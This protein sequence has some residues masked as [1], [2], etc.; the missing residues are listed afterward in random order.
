MLTWEGSWP[1]SLVRRPPWLQACSVKN[2]TKQISQWISSVLV[3]P[4]VQNI[5]KCS[6]NLNLYTM[7]KLNTSEFVSPVFCIVLQGQKYFWA[8]FVLGDWSDEQM[9]VVFF[10]YQMT[11]QNKIVYSNLIKWYEYR[12]QKSL[13][14]FG[15]YKKTDTVYW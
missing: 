10:C 13:L 5:E 8:C 1:N 15:Q 3:F 14:I 6:R 11:K 12:R 9:R 4:L 7:F 2:K